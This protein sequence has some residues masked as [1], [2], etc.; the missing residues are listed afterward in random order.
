MGRGVA[1]PIEAIA[2]LRRRLVALPARH[3][4]RQKLLASTAGLYGVSRATLHRRLRGERRPKDAHRSDRG[5]PRVMSAAE[6]E[7]WCEIVAAMKVRTTNRKGRCLS[8]A[9]V[10]ELLANH[11]VETP[12][13]FQKL[14]PGRLTVSTLNRHIRRLGYDQARMMREPPAVRFQAERSNVCRRRRL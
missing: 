1:V 3:P 12:D 8:N 2:T 5:Q 7:S 13:G 14:E 9:R 10:L 6:I 11:G 4:D